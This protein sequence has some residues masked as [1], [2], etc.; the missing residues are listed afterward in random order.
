MPEIVV[1][2][3]GHLTR[4]GLDEI[5]A[6]A[7]TTSGS[8]DLIVDCLDMTSYDIEARDAFIA[9]NRSNRKRV[10]RVAIITRRTTWHMVIRAIALAS[11]RSMRSFAT[12]DEARA[13]LAA[14]GGG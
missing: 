8:F 13:W 14:D 5:F 11:G 10:G 3:V 1:R 12:H 2:L 7:I 6:A 9:W 4:P